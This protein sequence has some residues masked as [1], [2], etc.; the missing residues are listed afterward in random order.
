MTLVVMGIAGC[1]AAVRWEKSGGSAADLQRDET[2]CVALATR[3]VTPSAQPTGT[4]TGAPVGAERTRIQASDTTVLD[5]CMKARGYTR[6]S[7]PPG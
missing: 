4:T 5:E 7:R 2:E 6:V 1:A 3:E